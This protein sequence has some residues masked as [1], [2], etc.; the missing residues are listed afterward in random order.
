MPKP[1]KIAAVLL[2]AGAS[3]RMHGQDK[4][5]KEIDGIPLIR[6]AA[7]TCIASQ[8]TETIVVLSEGNEDRKQALAGLNLHIVENH[9]AE[10]GMASSIRR[11][12]QACNERFQALVLV[13]GDMPD[14]R[15]TDIDALISA[16]NPERGA[17]ICRAVTSSGKP[18]HPVL[19]GA[20]HF[21]ALLALGG[22]S[23]AKAVVE[24]KSKHV[25][26]VITSEEG[27]RTD[28]DTPE[29]WERYLSDKS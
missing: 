27:A 16:F 15:A 1:T 23:G 25:K 29:D 24:A 17:T 11:G 14:V 26:N 6:R 18:G 4:L 13:L 12:V 3:S 5:L 22:D 8:A 9:E 10:T 2:A 19:F 28:L 20:D 21:A 7:L